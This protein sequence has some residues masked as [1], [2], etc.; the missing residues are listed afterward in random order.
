MCNFY[1]PATTWTGCCLQTYL[2]D[3]SALGPRL[4][5]AA[6]LADVSEGVLATLAAL[7]DFGYAWGLLDAHLARLQ[8]EVDSVLLYVECSS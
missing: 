1:L 5:E 2:R 8:A 4:G 3:L 6:R 7:A